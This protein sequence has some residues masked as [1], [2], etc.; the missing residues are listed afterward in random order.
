[1]TPEIDGERL[2]RD[3]D[4]LAG[5]G[6]TADGGVSRI[7]F[8]PADREGRAWVAG[9]MREA[10]LAVR[11]DPAGNTIAAYPGAPAGL[12]PIALASHTDTVPNGGRYDGALG[13]LAALAC[14]RALTTAG[15]RLRHPV[16]VINFMAEEASVGGGTLGSRAMA[17]LLDPRALDQPA[18][19][20]RTVAEHARAAGI[21]PAGMARAARPAGSL[22]AYLEL[23]IEQGGVLEAAGVPVGVV[24]GIVGIRRYAVTF[25]G[26]ANHAGTTPMDARRDALVLAAPFVLAVR[27]VAVEHGIVGTVGT[28]E[29]SPGAPNVIPG[30]VDL[31]FE[32]RGLDEAQL[33]R[34]EAT[35]RTYAGER[36]GRIA[37]ASGKAPVASDPV[38][39][40]AIAE[41]CERLG[42]PYRRMPSGAGH[43]AACLAAITRQGMIFVPSR[44]GISHAP[45]EYTE[46]EGCVNGARVLLG[47]LLALDE[48]LDR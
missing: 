30:R 48:R 44:A 9:R 12:A 1:M 3:L 20:G 14:G 35:L 13:V 15:L 29:I 6:L 41:A 8:S 10:G 21:D 16:E 46:P 2:L 38:V 45:G 40:D 47:A 43:D 34:A 11:T 39:V 18:S 4:E 32:I 26:A 27:D 23:H 17:G 42:L 33:N 25:E 24:E 36:G 37:R 7:A 5:I 19:D 28:F 22:A 31:S